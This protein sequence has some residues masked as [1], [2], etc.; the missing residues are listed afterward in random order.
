MDGYGECTEQV[1]PF[2]SR[3]AA[4]CI[5]RCPCTPWVGLISSFVDCRSAN[6]DGPKN[7]PK[8]LPLGNSTVP[9]IDEVSAWIKRNNT[10]PPSKGP[11]K[12]KGRKSTIQDAQS[13]YEQAEKAHDLDVPL[14][15]DPDRAF[16]DRWVDTLD[17][18]W[19]YDFA[20]LRLRRAKKGW[21]WRLVR[22]R[23][24]GEVWVKPFIKPSQKPFAERGVNSAQVDVPHKTSQ[25]LLKGLAQKAQ[26][27]WRGMPLTKVGKQ[28]KYTSRV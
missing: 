6:L 1:E 9:V 12:P 16:Y 4:V 24:N 27:R 19:N 22:I 20:D 8:I 18:R 25:E 3:G 15:G 10:L 7:N 21:K 11:Y 23:P 26:W 17:Y 13:N 28:M 5:F 2:P 14:W